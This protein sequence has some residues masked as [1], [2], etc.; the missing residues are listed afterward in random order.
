MGRHVVKGVWM[1]EVTKVKE[2]LEVNKRD[3]HF[4]SETS[5]LKGESEMDQSC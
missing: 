3:S 2:N 5:Y 1:T 4:G